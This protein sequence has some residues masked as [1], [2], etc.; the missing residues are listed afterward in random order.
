LSDTKPTDKRVK[1]ILTEAKYSET[2]ASFIRKAII[3]YAENKDSDKSLKEQSA[4][5]KSPVSS[6]LESMDGKLNEILSLLNS[7]VYSEPLKEDKPLKDR[8]QEKNKD[9]DNRGSFKDNNKDNRNTKDNREIREPKENK[10]KV[11]DNTANKTEDRSL[12]NNPQN[13]KENAPLNQ[14][15]P[16]ST[17][18]KSREKEKPY[19][20]NEDKETFRGKSASD[21]ENSRDNT[22]ESNTAKNSEPLDM[23]NKSDGTGESNGDLL[24]TDRN[25]K[26]SSLAQSTRSIIDSFFS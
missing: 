8:E 17:G 5:V 20:D 13:Y 26:D 9:R 3:F 25:T 6:Q 16:Q 19:R 15:S 21:T 7:P 18:E 10:G 14:N 12:K 4:P 23:D 11:K 24:K 2:M 1:E 22:E